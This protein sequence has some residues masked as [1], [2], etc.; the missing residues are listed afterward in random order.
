MPRMV[1]Q[2]VV[3]LPSLP[4]AW[5]AL[6]IEAVSTHIASSQV[7]VIEEPAGTPMTSNQSRSGAAFGSLPPK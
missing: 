2:R 4:L 7:P 3:R 5:S 6:L 1:V